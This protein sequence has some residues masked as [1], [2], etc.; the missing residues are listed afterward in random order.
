VPLPYARRRI[1]SLSI[2]SSEDPGLRFTALSNYD[3]YQHTYSDSTTLGAA[4]QSESLV[5]YR[6]RD[7]IF[8]ANELDFAFC[9]LPT[10]KEREH[11]SQCGCLR[12]GVV[13]GQ[14][15]VSK[16]VEAGI[17]S[18]FRC[19]SPGSWDRLVRSRYRSGVNMSV[20]KV[21]R[22]YQIVY[23]Y[24]KAVVFRKVNRC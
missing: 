15:D 2:C 17:R 24:T 10:W 22:E 6:I 7:P 3:Q 9:M 8:E 12:V 5:S 14:R 20:S 23:L 21:S 11:Q 4:C 1:A 18:Q 19:H 16:T 13:I